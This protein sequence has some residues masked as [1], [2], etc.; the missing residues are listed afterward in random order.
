MLKTI[1]WLGNR[2]RFID[3]AKLPLEESWIHADNHEVIASAI[4]GLKIRGAPLIGV[5][6]AYG[7][8]LAAL[9][10]PGKDFKAFQ[11]YY[12]SALKILGSTR[13][14]AVNLFW[15]LGRMEKAIEGV[16]SVEDARKSVI[17]E[18]MDIHRQDQEMCRL[19]GENGARLVP[20]SAG[21]LTHCNTG[22]LATGGEGTA[23]SVIT[24]AHSQGKHLKVFADETRPLLQGARLTV[25]ELINAGID[26][27]LITDSTAAFLMK[28]KKIDLVVVGA[29][30]IAANGD[31]ANKIGTYS[32]ALAANYHNVPF[33]VAAP[34]TTIDP[35]TASGDRIPIEERNASE[36][37]EGF[38]KRT[39]PAG[40]KVYS[41]A[42]DVTAASL[43][44]AIITDRGVYRPPFDFRSRK[45]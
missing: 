24:T 14:T 38:G 10:F 39:A 17:K 37:T 4:R 35:E 30:R 18:A 5:A 43:I 36:V 40:T 15:A 8:A 3:Q 12:S 41:P 28:Q 23:Q 33:Y 9:N 44:R 22:A 1:E 13:P 25:W 31:V 2:V 29:D 19:I 16:Q 34:F 7:A 45:T 42:F 11:L 21:I 32:L 6:A 27:T 26:V 20:Q